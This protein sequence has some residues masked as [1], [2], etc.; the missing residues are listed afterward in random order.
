M[1]ELIKKEPKIVKT[2][3]VPIREVFPNEEKHFT[4]WLEKNLHLLEMGLEPDEREKIVYGRLEIDLLVKSAEGK[5]VVIENQYN[6]SDN[7]HLAKILMYCTSVKAKA[8]IWIA[9]KFKEQHKEEIINQNK[10]GAH[11][12][13]MIEVNVKKIIEDPEEPRYII[14][15]VV[16]IAPDIELR[17][18]ATA[19]IRDLTEKELL[20]KR[21]WEGLL[22]KTNA[23][24]KL[25]SG[26]SRSIANYMDATSGISEARYTYGT[27]KDSIRIELYIDSKDVVVNKRIF[28][29]IMT[30][31]D[32]IEERFGVELNWDRLD[33]KRASRIRY[34]II[35]RDWTNES[36]WDEL[37]EE[38]SN[39][40]V[41][42]ENAIKDYLKI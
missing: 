18:I 26:R 24:T 38:M 28:D 33:D 4:P 40:M 5:P 9:E 8:G 41:M 37:H 1:E 10:S 2:K 25:F 30:H 31:K 29:D 17:D 12:I 3:S 20:R 21:F 16:I 23:K 32:E 35:D 6:T 36:K 11:N 22:V 7:D 14:D 34:I 13:Y 39:K 19:G 27:T 15:F 42:L